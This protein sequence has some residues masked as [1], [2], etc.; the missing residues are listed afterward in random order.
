MKA[1]NP[2]TKAWL[3]FWHLLLKEALKTNRKS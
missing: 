2:R 3:E 1:P